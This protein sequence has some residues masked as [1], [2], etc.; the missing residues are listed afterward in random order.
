[1]TTK[2]NKNSNLKASIPLVVLNKDLKMKIGKINDCLDPEKCSITK[3]LQ[4]KNFKL[5]EKKNKSDSKYSGSLLAEQSSKYFIF[6][7]NEDTKKIEAFPGDDWYT[8]KKD[9]QYNTM[10]L[11][12]AEEKLKEKSGYMDYIRNK[13]NIVKGGKKEKVFKEEKEIGTKISKFNDEDEDVL[14]EI[15]PYL[16][17]REQKSEEDRVED[18]DAEL[19]DIPSDLEEVFLG[20]LK[21][22]EKAI[23]NPAVDEDI[24]EEESESSDEFFGKNDE[25]SDDVDDDE[26]LSSILENNES[27]NEDQ[28]SQ[29]KFKKNDYIGTKRRAEE[30]NNIPNKIKKQKTASEMEDV[31]DNLFAKNK[32]MT[33]EKIVRELIRLDFRQEQISVNL[34]IILSRS[35]GKYAQGGNN[36]YFKKSYGEK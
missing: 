18:I 3:D 14:D 31:L 5:I 21:D 2:T 19:K 20:K 25:E 36:F 17:E 16:F 29:V 1:M 32:R 24:D 35:C 8:F 27:L 23:H 11:E 12:E 34:P 6:K 26:E 4:T 30:L 7:Y 28:A 9:L 22:K 15:R 33:Y 13:G 10:S